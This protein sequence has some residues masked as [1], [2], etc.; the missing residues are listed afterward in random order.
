[1]VV[2][3]DCAAGDDALAHPKA[4][5]DLHA[6][7]LLHAGRHL[8]SSEQRRLVL[9]PHGGEIAVA[10]HRVDRD[11]RRGLVGADRDLEA[12][13][14][15]GL[16]RTIGIGDLG[17]HH[18]AVRHRVGGGSDSRDARLEY[19]FRDRA[20]LD[21]HLLADADERNV[22][23]GQLRVEPHGREV[24]D[25]VERVAVVVAHILA[26]PDLAG[27]D[28]AVDWSENRRRAPDGAFPFNAAISSSARPP[29]RR[30][31]RRQLHR[32]CCA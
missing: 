28:G 7:L 2:D 27:D 3:E 32:F 21:L 15:F 19:P 25:R 12:R 14:H 18:D 6:A 31:P 23:L 30:S 13:E 4:V 20:E 5:A 1:M 29:L 26:Q 16:E 8:A 17:T 10:N 11:S 24:G 9:H 22:A